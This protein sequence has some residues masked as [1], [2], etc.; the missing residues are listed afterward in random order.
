CVAPNPT[1]V[2][3]AY[4]LTLLCAAALDGKVSV[5]ID[6][7][8]VVFDPGTDFEHLGQGESDTV[9]I[10]YTMHDEHG[11]SSSSWVDVTVTGEN[12]APV[13]VADGAAIGENQPLGIDVLA[14]DTDV[15][16][17][18]AL[19]LVSAAAPEGKGAATIDGSSVLMDA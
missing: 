5:I 14:N 12:D 2:Y 3:S 13:A 9:R 15:D 6:C 10:A 8:T 7:N 18:H 4:V 16:D 19:T 17:G 11:A 1:N